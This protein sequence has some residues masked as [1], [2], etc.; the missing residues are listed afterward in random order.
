MNAMADAD[1]EIRTIVVG[2]DGSEDAQR[3]V[4]WTAR[5][6]D[7]IGATVVVVHAIGLLDHLPDGDN[8]PSISIT[9][10]IR[11]LLTTT[12]SEP[13]RGLGVS[14]ECVMEEGPPLLAIPRVA[15]RHGAGLTVVASHGERLGSAALLGSTSHGL[16]SVSATPVVIVPTRG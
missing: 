2:T 4:E 15:E 6:A 7:Q 10:S 11:D 5:L 16:A 8:V 3:A 14:H 13:L 9:E 12:W 1:H